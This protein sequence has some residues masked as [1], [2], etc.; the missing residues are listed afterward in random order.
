MS[1]GNDLKSGRRESTTTH[2]RQGTPIA[3]ELESHWITAV[4]ELDIE[5]EKARPAFD[6]LLAMYSVG[7]RAYHNL[8]H[9]KDM[10]DFLSSHAGEIQG[11]P[12]VVLA[13]LFHD[14]I[15]DSQAKD[16]EERSAALVKE[17][18]QPLGLATD[19]IE[20]IASLVLST[21]KHQPLLAGIDN[22]LF[23]DADLAILGASPEKYLQYSNSIREEYSWVPESNYIAE[24]KKVLQ[25]FLDRPTLYFTQS[26]RTVL[27]ARAKENI[28]AEIWY[29][30][31]C[32]NNTN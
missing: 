32:V 25:I 17:L 6:K 19:H 4:R 5:I 24:R 20:T 23:L 11:M 14:A 15:Y 26:V 28:T 22:E 30:A 27:E 31:N 9:I 3:A 10:L 16:N 18:M 8:S 7:K 2:E 12:Q 1:M 13:A 29:L 21:K